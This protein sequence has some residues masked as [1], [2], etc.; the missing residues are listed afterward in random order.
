MKS[1]EE[2]E[3][4]YVVRRRLHQEDPR[5]LNSEPGPVLNP[6]RRPASRCTETLK[7]LYGGILTQS[8]VGSTFY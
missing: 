2:Q 4:P 6:E 3:T 8:I 1:G 5:I 7:Y